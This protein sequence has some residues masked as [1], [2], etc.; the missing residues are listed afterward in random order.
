MAKKLQ[1][2]N[3]FFYHPQW[4]KELVDSKISRR[5]RDLDRAELL[6][7]SAGMKP[8]YDTPNGTAGDV[9]NYN[10]VDGLFKAAHVYQALGYPHT[11]RYG[12]GYDGDRHHHLLSGNDTYL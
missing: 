4:P 3:G 12:G 6:L 5:S 11:Q 2:P 7:R 8:T 1:A 9:T 10:A